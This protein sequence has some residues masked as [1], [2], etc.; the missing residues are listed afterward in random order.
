MHTVYRQ[1]CSLI[2]IFDVCNVYL[3]IHVFPCFSVN[4]MHHLKFM[5]STEKVLAGWSGEMYSK[6]INHF[7]MLQIPTVHSLQ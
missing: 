1:P 4:F 7:H 3:F 5:E 6:L 2:I